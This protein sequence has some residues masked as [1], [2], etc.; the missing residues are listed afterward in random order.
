MS[1]FAPTPFIR[2][3]ATDLKEGHQFNKDTAKVVFTDADAKVQNHLT[4]DLSFEQL[5]TA[6]AVLLDITAAHTLAVGEV[7]EVELKAK[8]APNR[9]TA[10]TQVGHS[11]VETSYVKEKTGISSINKQPWRKTGVATSSLVVGV[12][13][14]A[15]H[16]KDVQKHLAESAESVFS[17]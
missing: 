10:K 3:L 15:A 9:V 1:T 14:K 6:Q 4:G 17:N 11:A 12:G 7:C 2:A 8:T 16:Y 5:K 13:R